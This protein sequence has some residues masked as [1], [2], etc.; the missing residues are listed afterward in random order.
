[1]VRTIQYRSVV[2]V[3]LV[4]SARL[5]RPTQF[6]VI[7]ALIKVSL[8]RQPVLHLPLAKPLLTEML[9]LTRVRHPWATR[10][11]HQQQ[12]ASKLPWLVDVQLASLRGRTRLLACFV[13]KDSNADSQVRHHA[14]VCPDGTPMSGHNTAPDARLVPSAQVST[15][16]PKPSVQLVS[17][18]SMDH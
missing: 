12:L 3:R 9:Y 5:P 11:R 14:S 8:D 16:A 4:I 13:L 7:L 17:T 6:L 10:Q 15:G 18:H 2:S 1:M